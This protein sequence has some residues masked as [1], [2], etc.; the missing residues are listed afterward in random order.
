[1][2]LRVL[3]VDSADLGTQRC[4]MG[5]GLMSAL[6]LNLG[7]PLMVSTPGGTCLCTAWPRSDLAEGFLQMDLKCSSPSLISHPLKHLNLNPSHLTPITCSKLRGIKVSVVIQ[8]AEFKKDALPRYVHELLK[9][10][11]KGLYVHKKHVINFGDFD[12]E[13]KYA[14]IESINPDTAAAGRITSKTGVEIVGTQTLG[15]YK[16]QLQDQPMVPLG[17][18]D[19]VSASL[20]EMLQLP[21]FYSGTLNSLGVSCPRGVLLVGPPG[22]GKTLLVRRVAG[23]VGA[24]LVVIRGPEVVGSR[25]GE[26]EETLRAVFAR[27]RTAAEEGLCVLFLDELDSLFPRRMGSSTPENRLVAQLLTLMDGMN[28]SD[29]FLIVG[30]TNQPDSLDP[31]LRRP[32]RFDREVIIGAPTLKQRKAILSVLCERMPVCPSVDFAELAQR[33]IG[34]VGADLNALCREAA[35]HAIR[36]NSQGSKEQLVGMKHFQEALKTVSPSCLRSSLGRTELSPIS[37]EQIGGLNEVKL[38]LRQSIEWPMK[39]PEAFVR[40][41]LSRPR[42]VLLYGPPGCAKTTLVRAAATSSHCSFLSVSGADLYSPFV[43]D[44][45]KALA[46]LFRQAR[47]HTP[48]IL[49]LDEIDS[50]IGSRSGS[51]TPNSVQTRLLS[52]LLNELDGV[53][54]K[55][56]ERRG[57]EKE[58]QAEGE[59]ECHTHQQLDYQEVCNKDVMIVAATNRPDTVD[60]ALLRPGRLDHIIYVPPP[61]EQARLAILKVCTDTMPVDAD[62]YL[63]ALAT[64]TELYSGA[65]LENLCKEAALLALQEEN[66]EVSSIKYKYFLKSL[67]KMSPSLTAQQIHMY[68]TPL[69]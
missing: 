35:M 20:K 11:L 25:P 7:S 23:E 27:A 61:D 59:Q 31:A 56:L 63:E 10:M 36:Y 53:G 32:G 13:I 38:K 6:G 18:L 49:F 24:S 55:T 42:G 57:T 46:Q 66:M 22:V 14:V 1:M 28:Q 8:S 67:S 41:G 3:S 9:D 5:R 60:S 30:A 21:L 39:Y 62:V 64:H 45:E 52:V 47:A 50:L 68:Q 69:R 29:R 16:R 44:S 2:A 15:H 34:Y 58:L 43:G 37:W 17:G 33:T 26:S 65:D 54:V 19:E 4:R 40:L 51:H 48:C 12:T